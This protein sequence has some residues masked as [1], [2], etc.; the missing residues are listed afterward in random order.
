MHLRFFP[1]RQDLPP[2]NASE[3]CATEDGMYVGPLFGRKNEA[4]NY[5]LPEFEYGD[6]CV[7]EHKTPM[8]SPTD[9]DS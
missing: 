3:I 8:G 7:V 1:Q 6:A 5:R 9:H 2:G 4:G